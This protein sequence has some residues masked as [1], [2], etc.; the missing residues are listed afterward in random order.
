MNYWYVMRPRPRG[1][2]V[3]CRCKAAE[4]KQQQA[5]KQATHL[6][7]AQETTA[8][9]S[10]V[11]QQRFMAAIRALRQLNEEQQ[12][13]ILD[14][15]RNPPGSSSGSIAAGERKT[16]C[17]DLVDMFATPSPPREPREAWSLAHDTS[18]SHSA[19]SPA[20][21]ASEMRPEAASASAP[22]A[23]AGAAEPRKRDG[24][25]ELDLAW[26]A[27]DERRA[28][29]QKLLDSGPETPLRK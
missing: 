1:V 6:A 2:S 19:R 14:L 26:K 23:T 11:K 27:L 12:M 5:E 9:V 18:N 17:G 7:M 20:E 24:D 21:T 8:A 25:W 15:T 29:L 16:A 4:L 10:D 22:L 13:Q 3:R 28:A